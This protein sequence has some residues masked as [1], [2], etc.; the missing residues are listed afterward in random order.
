MKRGNRLKLSETLGLRWPEDNATSK[1]IVHIA[2]GI[3]F[4]IGFLL[5]MLVLLRLTEALLGLGS[6]AG[7]E[8][9][10]A[11]IRNIGLFLAAITGVPFLIWRSIVAQKQVDVAEQGHITDRINKAVEGLGAD[12][13]VKR[14]RRRQSGELAYVTAENGEPDYSQPIMEEV[15]QPNL[16]VRI[17][18]IFALERI[19]QDSERDHIQIMEILCAYIRENAQTVVEPLPEGDPTPQE[20]REWVKHELK[21]PRQDLAVALEVIRRRKPARKKR[22][23]EHGFNVSLQHTVMRKVGPL[24]C[25]LESADLSDSEWQGSDLRSVKL[26][27][28]VLINAALQVANLDHA[29]LQGAKLAGTKMQATYLRHA[30]LQSA[31]LYKANLE[32]AYLIGAEFDGHT[33]LF[34]ANLQGAVVKSVDF[35]DVPQITEHLPGMFGDG[36]VTLPG[37]HGPSHPDWPSHWP[38]HKLSVAQFDQE[39]RKWQSD[40]DNYTPPEAPAKTADIL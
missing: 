24:K 2:G 13:T 1:R 26:Q 16:E 11:A 25:D 7:D 19:S 40:S 33:N 10:S 27:E 28:A 15:T 31:V 37:G 34:E 9:Q 12:K 30:K 14:Q 36:T 5:L 3:S 39:W 21:P 38:R 17:G 4:F 6:Y 18:A 8:T 35:S 23:Q 22:E 32:G 29:N 20:W